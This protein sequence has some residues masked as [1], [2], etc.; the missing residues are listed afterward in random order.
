VRTVKRDGDYLYKSFTS[1]FA[2]QVIQNNARLISNTRT[3]AEY[4]RGGN[5]VYVDNAEITAISKFR[6]CF[7]IYFSSE[8]RIT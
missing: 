3:I 8:S 6:A 5:G 2:F 4:T 7:G 1:L